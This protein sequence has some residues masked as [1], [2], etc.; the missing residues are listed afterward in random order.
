MSVRPVCCPQRLLLL[1]SPKL[2]TQ[3]DSGTLS[4]MESVCPQAQLKCG[5]R[6]RAPNTDTTESITMENHFLGI[7]SC[8]SA[9]V[10]FSLYFLSRHIKQL[11]SARCFGRKAHEKEAGPPV[12]QHV[13]FHFP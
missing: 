1:K 3:P 6:E 9:S 8:L 2:L 7:Y 4:M 12:K 11:P 5:I 10:F 13:G